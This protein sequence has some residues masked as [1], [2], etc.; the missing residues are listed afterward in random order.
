MRQRIIEIMEDVLDEKIKDLNDEQ[1]VPSNLENWDSLNHLSLITTLEEEFNVQ[2]DPNEI[3]L[4]N[5][6]ITNIIEVFAKHGLN[7]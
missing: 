7:F 6:G 1:I 2:F 4:M 5:K 3:E